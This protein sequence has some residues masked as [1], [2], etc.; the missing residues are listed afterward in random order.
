[1][2]TVQLGEYPQEYVGNELNNQLKTLGDNARTGKVY[3][4]MMD[5]KQVDF[6]E[7]HDAAGERYVKVNNV[8]DVKGNAFAD[9]TL[10]AKG[11]AYF[12]RVMPILWDVFRQGEQMIA[13]CST[14]VATVN[15]NALSGESSS[16]TNSYLR[17]WLNDYFIND[18]LLG[19]FADLRTYYSSSATSDIDGDCLTDKMWIPSFFEIQQFYP[20]DANRIKP[21]NDF[22]V[23]GFYNNGTNPFY[24]LRTTIGD[25]QIAKV[26]NVPTAGRP[27]GA[28]YTTGSKVIPEGCVP[29][30]VMSSSATAKMFNL[31]AT[32]PDI[33]YDG[34]DHTVKFTKPTDLIGNIS[35]E[36]FCNGAATT[37]MLEA[38]NYKIVVYLDN[39]L[40]GVC[41]TNIIVCSHSYGEWRIVG[42]TSDN[43]LLQERI[44]SECGAV[45][46]RTIPP[47]CH[48]IK[49]ESNYPDGLILTATLYLEQETAIT[50][51]EW[52]N[53]L[54][55]LTDIDGLVCQGTVRHYDPT[56]EQWCT[57]SVSRVTSY[58][59]HMFT[60]Y[61][62]NSNDIIVPV[63]TT[64]L[65]LTLSDEVFDMRLTA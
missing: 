16:W 30:F 17:G 8:I 2:G 9:G 27:A 10:M 25:A 28:A 33:V 24:L 50:L 31:P 4:A 53:Y 18:A 39:C 11:Q 15:F 23:V 20:L 5:G 1:M 35:H 61:Y 52:V 49:L 3:T 59:N 40:V 13:V 26:N 19:D 14:P 56:S 43:L 36:Y 6:Y 48:H 60:Y 22:A 63:R 21:L 55:C 54:N 38:G 46:R 64:L 62:E 32:L 57:A 51:Q 44:C 29:S 34:N 58:N 37:A 42:S 65:H 47:Y 7:Y 45:D 41:T 12:F